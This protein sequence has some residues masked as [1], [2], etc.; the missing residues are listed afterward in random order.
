MRPAALLG[1][2][3][4]AAT[5][6]AAPAANAFTIGPGSRPGVAVDASGTAYIAWN[7]PEVQNVAPLRFCRLP[8]GATAC[9][10]GA[11]G[12]IATPGT[13]LSK[14]FIV[15]SGERVVIVQHRYGGD[16]PGFGALFAYTSLN[17][18]VSFGAGRVVGRVPFE[19]AVAGPG[20]TMSGATDA[21]AEGLGFQNVPLDGRAPVDLN[22]VSTNPFAIL[23]TTHPYQGT[24]GLVDASTPLTVFTNSG[25]AAQF[26]RY[27]GSGD[28]NDAGNWTAPV[29][30]GS[31]RSPRL[32]G[33]PTGL[34]LLGRDPQG[35]SF[36]RKFDGASFG[37][38]VNLGPSSVVQHLAQD[39][40]GRLHAV[41][42]RSGQRGQDL[43]H[44]VSDDGRA[45]RSSTVV[46]QTLGDGSGGF[47]DH[48]RVAAAADH[49]G[50]A[51]WRA[52]D[53]IRVAAVGAVVPPPPLVAPKPP[54]PVVKA[55]PS[56]TASGLA[57]RTGRR[58][59]ITIKGRLVLPHGITAAKGCNGR[60]KV[61]V[62]RR[63]TTIA[64]KTVRVRSSCALVFRATVRRARVGRSK[65]LAIRLRFNGN[66]AL[67]PVTKV[68]SI[69]VKR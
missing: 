38:G 59:R 14:P 3:L 49:R 41:F 44:A 23:S 32:A 43:I 6:L 46:T 5:L 15:V 69:S 42:S 19:E 31:V 56:L 64:S 66:N 27:D 10:A 30:I 50:V 36:V 18:G 57:R 21:W 48:L 16:V 8:R 60:V 11:A 34:F 65:K 24:V 53:G 28:L 33:G 7:G 25:D 22:G 47:F 1:S 54:A 62:R 12:S 55:K 67:T 35:S 9:D 17:R 29:E 4:V 2:I 63:T 61:S 52:G 20:D 26:R 68:G 58:Y 51:V 13:S 45:W 39:A 40:A 37:P